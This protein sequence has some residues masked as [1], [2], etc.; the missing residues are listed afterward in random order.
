MANKETILYH[1]TDFSALDGILSNSEV[2]LVVSPFEQ[3]FFDVK[4]RFLF[5]QERI[6]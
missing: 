3:G 2:R 5:T 1:Y 6:K 4:P